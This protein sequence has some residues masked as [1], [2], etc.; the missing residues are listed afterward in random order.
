MD[1]TVLN[2][3]QRVAAQWDTLRAN[4]YDESVI[5]KALE[6]APVD[7]TQTVID[8]GTGTGFIA[9]SLA[10]FARQVIGVD[11]S[12]AM[13]N[14]ARENIAKL[15]LTNVEFRRGD[16][17]HLPLEDA[18]AD[19]VFANMALHHAPEPRA[20]LREMARVLKPGGRAVITDATRH[21]FEWFKT[22]MADVWLGFTREEIETWF[23][24]VG[25]S[26]FRYELVG[27]R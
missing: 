11:F 24:S 3:F 7:K 5:V 12:D 25:L 2:Y 18:G 8:A 20:A 27:T 6:H 1:T 13:L 10:P 19:A 16:M 22:E 26:S 15:G 4:Y 23:A 9:A 14:V 17:E 21:A